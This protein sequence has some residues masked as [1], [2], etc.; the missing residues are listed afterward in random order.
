MFPSVLRKWCTSELKLNPLKRFLD[1]IE[2][3]YIS[4]IGIRRAESKK[5]SSYLEKEWSEYFD[6]YVWRPIIEWTEQDV[7]GIHSKYKIMPNDL[8]L[9]HS[10]NRV[11]CWPCI[12]CRKKEISK[13]DNQRIDIIRRLEKYISQY[14][15]SPPAT[16]FLSR[17]SGRMEIDEI[18]QWSK[19]SR[20]GRQYQ[21][22]ETEEAGCVRWGLC[23]I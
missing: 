3:D 2:D 6:C 23:N 12:Q 20:G 8:Y 9:D 11:G 4:C 13:I 14:C 16:F 19:T 18:I 10:V 15:K 17:L 21:L 5:R 22:F 1:S 7:I